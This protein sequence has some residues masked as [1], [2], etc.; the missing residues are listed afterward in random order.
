MHEGLV[1]EFDLTG[2]V[3]VVTGA[4]S[5][6]GQ[7]VARTLAQAGATPVLADVNEAGMAQTAALVAEAGQAAT[8]VRLDVTDRA[9]VDALAEQVIAR[10]G[11][12]DIWVNCAGA[13]SAGQ[14]TEMTEPA[15]ER[16][17]AINLKGTYWGCAA[18]GR[19][20]SARGRGSIVNFS[21]AGADFPAPGLSVYSM[22]KSAVNALT[23][24]LARELGPQGVRANAVAPGWVETPLAL[25][26]IR[27]A[28]G[29][30]DPAD[31]DSLVRS[32]AEG[33]PL[34]TIGTARD[35]ALA[36]LF[37]AADAS[38]F[39]TGQILRPNGG[40]VMP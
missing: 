22:T 26:S 13:I 5:G 38:R 8:A 34:G 35:M 27:G 30:I 39:M 23:R 32:R 29:G 36:V 3:A 20:M 16:L 33:A 2:R 37:L 1:A 28:D 14:V 24:T 7:E 12:L 21:S 40:I 31:R 25:H 9:A 10:H 19:V 6:I 18:A 4:G 15:L 11:R 17:L